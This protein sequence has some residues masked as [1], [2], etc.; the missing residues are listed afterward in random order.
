MLHV[1]HRRFPIDTSRPIHDAR[2]E[3]EKSKLSRTE[4]LRLIKRVRDLGFSDAEILREILRGEYGGNHRRSLVIEWGELLGLDA[5]A[6]LRLA[7]DSGLI[8]T[9]HP[10]KKK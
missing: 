9:P 7:S 1:S 4:R 6:A 5:T 2:F 10:P 3:M 8:P